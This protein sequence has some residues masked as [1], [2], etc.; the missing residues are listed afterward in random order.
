MLLLPGGAA[1]SPVRPARAAARPPARPRPPPPA[2]LACASIS[3][4]PRA[5]DSQLNQVWAFGDPI[6]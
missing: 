5:R 3:L 2:R 1:A 6:G 4:A